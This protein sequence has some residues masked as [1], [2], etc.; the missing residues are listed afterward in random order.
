MTSDPIRTCPKCKGLVRK[1][2]GSGAGIIFKG[3]G[4]YVTDYRS[5]SYKKKAASEKKGSDSGSKEKNG[6]DS[7]SKEKK[8][9][10]S[11]TSGPAK[12]KPSREKG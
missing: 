11:D 8:P 9:G 1:I 2:I 7:G 6:S 5:E 12:S 3:Q 4:F 10:S